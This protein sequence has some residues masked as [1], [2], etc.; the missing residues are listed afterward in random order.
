VNFPGE[1]STALAGRGVN[2]NVEKSN[3]HPLPS[4]ALAQVGSVSLRRPA[5]DLLL[6][7][8]KNY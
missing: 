7:N 5:E 3:E 6:D 1:G 2:Q 8:L 4:E